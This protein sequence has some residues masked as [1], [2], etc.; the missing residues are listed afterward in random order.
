ME[1]L[2]RTHFVSQGLLRVSRRHF[3]VLNGPLEVSDGPLEISEGLL[4]M[5]EGP[6]GVS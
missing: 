6:G 2:K 3:L 5:S 1:S 4:G